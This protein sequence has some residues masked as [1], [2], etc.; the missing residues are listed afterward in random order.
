MGNF[1]LL[2]KFGRI[3]TEFSI[4][5]LVV[6]CSQLIYPINISNPGVQQSLVNALINSAVGATCLD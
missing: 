3:E 1:A 4:M 5:V 6:P 2:R